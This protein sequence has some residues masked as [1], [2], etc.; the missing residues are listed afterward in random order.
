MN[1]SNDMRDWKKEMRMFCYYKVL[2]LPVKQHTI[3]SFGSR[4]GL[5]I[6]V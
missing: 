5:V 6:H 4:L 2:A 3:V 1:D